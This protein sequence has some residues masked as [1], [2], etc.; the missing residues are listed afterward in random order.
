MTTDKAFE[1]LKFTIVNQNK[2]NKTDLD[3]LIILAEWINQSKKQEITNNYLFAKMY[4]YNFAHEVL[5][6]KDSYKNNFKI[7][8]SK[9]HK[10]L[11]MPLETVIKITMDKIN[12]NEFDNFSNEIGLPDKHPA[13]KTEEEEI[14][15]KEIIKANEPKFLRY[16]SGIFEYQEFEEN[17]TNQITESINKYKDLK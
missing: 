9:I 10:V 5:F 2:P 11:E 12:T 16:A 13:L 15:S 3:A 1:R 7:S 6:Y 4:C 17:I 14:K 8:Q